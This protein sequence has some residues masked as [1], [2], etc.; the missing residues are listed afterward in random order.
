VKFFQDDSEVILKKRTHVKALPRI[1]EN[2]WRPPQYF[3]N[4][5]NAAAI[6]FDVETNE[7]DFEHGPGWGRGSGHIVGLAIG[8]VDRAGERG[9]WYF[10]VRHSV[11]TEWNLDPS[12]VFAWAKQT[13]ETSIPKIGAN[14][15]YDVGWLTTEGIQ[16]GGRLHDVQFAEALID[17][18]AEVNLDALAHKY[19]SGGKDS[20]SMYEWLA[21]AYGGKAN[22]RQRANIWRAPPRLVGPYGEADASLPLTIMQAQWPILEREG[23]IELFDMENKLIRLL[24][25]MRLAGVTVDLAYADELYGELGR[26]VERLNQKIKDDYGFFVNVNSGKD[27]AKLFDSLGLDYGKTAD[28]NPSFQKEFL[29][30]VEHP[31]GKLVNDI[32]EHDK[33]RSTFLQS[34]ILKRARPIA[35]SNSLATLH[36]S[37]HPLKGD[38]NGTKTGR[39]ASSD[40]NLQNIPARTKLGKRVRTAFV[41]DPGQLAWE[42]NDYSQIE[43]RMLAHFADGETEAEKRAAEALRKTYNDNPKTDYHDKV[44]GMVCP[45]MGWDFNDPDADLR[46]TRRKPIK[47]V[48]F[49]LIYG[50][51]EKALAFK[52]G[53]S[54]EQ[55]REFFKAYHAAAPYAKATMKAIAKEVQTFGYVRTILGRRTRFN[56]WESTEDKSSGVPLEMALRYFGSNIK[57][58][59]DY[60]GTNYKLQGSAAD[61]I[62]K[63]MVQCFDDGVFDVTG[64]PK[65]QV[66]DELDFS[67]IDD[68]PQQQEA[69]RYMRYVLENATPCRVPILVDHGRGPNWGAIN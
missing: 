51:S 11:E 38:E 44:Y 62:K 60:R 2:G 68:S 18:T 47:N 7:P 31:A 35:G 29:K 54:Q 48:N 53:F 34:Y 6:S 69:F 25:R 63:A 41:A 13:L 4:L 42:K 65:L 66:H 22:D 55:A 24:V 50:Q 3:P 12:N 43:Y 32:R 16:V 56:L 15:I 28:G 64:V 1:E 8:A 21:S 23:L 57:R 61:V 10:P 58:A 46:A 59:F 30:G 52:A 40:P 67:V 17:E 5:S 49:G 19:A 14:L 36:C 37:F 39:F 45:L 20:A 27:L 26:E 9:Q 33:I